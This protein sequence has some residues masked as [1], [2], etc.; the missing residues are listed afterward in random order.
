MLEAF[1]CW[2][3]GGCTCEY[4]GAAGMMLESGSSDGTSLVGPCC[5]VESVERASSEVGTVRAGILTE[6]K[7]S[8]VVER[9]HDSLDRP[10]RCK[11]VVSA[12]VR[13]QCREQDP[14]IQARQLEPTNSRE[15]S[16]HPRSKS[17]IVGSTTTTVPPSPSKLGIHS[18]SLGSHISSPP[19]FLSEFQRRSR[20]TSIVLTPRRTFKMLTPTMQTAIRRM[21]VPA[22]KMTRAG[23]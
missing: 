11:V 22:S 18:L 12:A 16:R 8:S 7:I 9:E 21:K 4:V 14:P 10:G 19:F 20:S 23:R 13:Y 5:V 1:V 3:S 6:K 2:K 17:R 15:L